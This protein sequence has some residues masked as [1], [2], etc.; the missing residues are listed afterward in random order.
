MMLLARAQ[1]PGTEEEATAYSSMIDSLRA[2]L[3]AVA[4][5]RLGAADVAE[6]DKHLQDWSDRL[7]RSDAPETV[8]QFGH[9][10][11]HR[12]RGQA[13]VPDMV[14]SESSADHVVATVRFGNFYLGENGAAHGGAVPLLFDELL[15]HLSI[16]GGRP[17]S[18][19]AYLK[20]DFRSVTPIGAE[21]TARGWIEREEGRKLFIRGTLHHADVLC[22]D[23]EALF[24][25]LRP[26]Q[27]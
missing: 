11:G 14:V 24:V 4:A 12:N 7:A 9:W 26:G 16:E 10:A 18:R 27:R 19:T 15:G 2:F 5:A 13:L 3:D 22:V 1:T 20:T 25:R 8:R 17:P 6:L 23:A 21:L